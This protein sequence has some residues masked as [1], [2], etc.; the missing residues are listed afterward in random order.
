MNAISLIERGE[1]S[2]T[3][4]SLHQLSAA[5]GA[6]ITEFFQ[7]DD[8]L[9][10]VHVPH[11][12]RLEYRKAGLVMESLGAGLSNQQLE[13]FL[14]TIEPGS[15]SDRPVEHPGQEFV[16]C[17]TGTAEYTVA[18]HAYTLKPGDSLLLD[19]SR[20]HSY[21]NVSGRPATLLLVFQASDNLSLARER[22]L[23]SGMMD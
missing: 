3:V 13:P 17:L 14:I 23:S 16:Y 18:E 20:P 2:P 9:S 1:N 10:V 19:A 22:H 11:D 8:R 5:L 7:Q 21:R 12:Q 6:S 4:S 15:A